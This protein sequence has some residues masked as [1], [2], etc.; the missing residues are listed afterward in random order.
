MDEISKAE[1]KDRKRRGEILMEDKEEAAWEGSLKHQDAQQKAEER[2]EFYKHVRGLSGDELLHEIIRQLKD[3]SD[4][5][6]LRRQEISITAGL[7]T[8]A[9]AMNERPKWEDEEPEFDPMPLG[10]RHIP[11]EQEK[12]L[13]PILDQWRWFAKVLENIVD[14]P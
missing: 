10:D 8:A 7:L 12:A 14:R 6:A 5:R 3:L 4:S 11:G 2:R 1:K 9:W 13:R